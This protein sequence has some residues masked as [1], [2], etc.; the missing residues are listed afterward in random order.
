MHTWHGLE[1]GVKS[2]HTHVQEGLFT[3]SLCNTFQHWSHILHKVLVFS[4]PLSRAFAHHSSKLYSSPHLL[5]ITLVTFGNLTAQIHKL[6][7]SM[8]RKATTCLQG[9]KCYKITFQ[10]GMDKQESWSS[11]GGCST[12]RAMGCVICKWVNICPCPGV[13]MCNN[14]CYRNTTCHITQIMTKMK[15]D[16]CVSSLIYS[17]YTYFN[18]II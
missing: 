11:Q 15:S 2:N 9:R 8:I 13:K 10:L 4:W 5:W 12:L 1:C 7:F 6:S 18:C 14:H 16:M 17:K 3:F